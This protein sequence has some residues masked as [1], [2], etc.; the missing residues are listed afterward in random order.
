[1]SDAAASCSL[2]VFPLKSSPPHS[3][4]KSARL[5]AEFARAFHLLTQESQR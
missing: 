5:S 4:V 3:P 2:K 1:M